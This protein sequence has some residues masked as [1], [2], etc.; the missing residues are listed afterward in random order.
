M[1]TIKIQ[2]KDNE[3][4]IIAKIVKKSYHNAEELIGVENKLHIECECQTQTIILRIVYQNFEDVF[5]IG[6]GG[7]HFLH[8]NTK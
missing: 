2:V 4:D 3:D 7:V 5:D 6:G 1:R 8:Q